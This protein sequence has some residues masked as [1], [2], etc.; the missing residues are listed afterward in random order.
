M[1]NWRLE[2]Q[3]IAAIDQAPLMAAISIHGGFKGVLVAL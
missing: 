2:V 3:E 1:G